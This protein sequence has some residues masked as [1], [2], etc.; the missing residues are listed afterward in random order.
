MRASVSEGKAWQIV[1]E[2]LTVPTARKK[3]LDEVNTRGH[4]NPTQDTTHQ[5]L[6]CKLI[7]SVL[8]GELTRP[9][10]TALAQQP[11]IQAL[12]ALSD[13]EREDPDSCLDARKVQCSG[14][15]GKEASREPRVS[16]LDVKDCTDASG[17]AGR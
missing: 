6:F 3:E 13:P 17:E 8:F 12:F 5:N 16:P 10:T 7:V 15:G 14:Q 1:D 11:A 9:S 4:S 2:P